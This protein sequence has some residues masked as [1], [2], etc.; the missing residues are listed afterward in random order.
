MKPI[1]CCFTLL[2]LFA[3]MSTMPGAAFAQSLPGNWQQLSPKDFA[4]AVDPFYDTATNRPKGDFD[5]Q[6]VRQHA[7]ALF[8]DF[9]LATAPTT[10]FPTIYR[11]Y[12]A[13]WRELS[14]EQL[15][16]VL[17]TL[18]A[19]QDD[20][21]GRPYE[22]NLSKAM[23]MDWVGVPF[24]RMTQEVI[25]F[26]DAGG[27]YEDVWPNDLQDYA[28]LA[29]RDAQSVD[30]SFSVRWEGLLT[31]PQTG[32]Y[33]FF[34]GP[35]N[36]SHV[37]ANYSV[38]QTMKVSVNGQEVLS[39]TPEQWT[40]VSAAVQL[41]AGQPAPIQVDLSVT[42]T[43]LPYYA[44]HALL[45]WEGPGIAKTIIPADRF[46]LP[47][48]GESGLQ[49]TWTLDGEANPIVRVDDNVDFAWTSGDIT[50]AG[51]TTIKEDLLARSWEKQT[52]AE[53]LDSL[54]GAD[55]K[56]KLHSW[57]I[58]PR[59]SS[60]NLSSSQRQQFL[61]ILLSRPALLDALPTRRAVNLY[62]AYR[63][64]AAE[65]ALDVFGQWAVRNAGLECAMLDE[66]HLSNFDWTNREACHDMAVAVTQELP[67]HADRLQ[68]EFLELPDGS[69]CLPVAY[70]LGYS[71]LGRD[72]LDE[73]TDLLDAK[74]AEETLTGDKRVNWL[75]A[76][77]HAH[78]IRLGS[79]NP[80]TVIKDRPMD[81][82]YMLDTAML[83]AED[84][85]LKLKI[86]QQI[87]GRLA[88][89]RKFDEARALLDEAASSAPAERAADIAAWRAGINQLEA[90]DAAA[91]VARAAE[92]KQSYIAALERRRDKAAAAGK[93]NAVSRYEALIEAA[94]EE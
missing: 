67:A 57:T 70:T 78:E 14:E 31:A 21:T 51:D 88:I 7:S 24:D 8:L 73:W 50:V 81:G 76:R 45:A 66:E 38:A 59:L 63:M 86:S 69:C 94:N 46:T 33:K 1:H 56:A 93:T 10:D 3:A 83:A 37:F 72:K 35:V 29:I 64:G 80:Y 6:A 54:I 12:R 74:L 68:E 79:R 42:S 53:F 89:T 65:T 39:A 13:G 11:L 30:G 36:T 23:L 48:G 85:D 82:R 25:S 58:D 49:A 92:A 18:A 32:Q 75:I 71:Y 9:D 60:Q 44:A 34:I 22:E 40:S 62:R 26:F 61:E 20:W 43:E 84:A 52:S 91:E 77:A 90:A 28:R 5:E 47:G 55:G 27:T 2:A 19:R 15:E 87:A 41:T 4:Y 17:A 16:D